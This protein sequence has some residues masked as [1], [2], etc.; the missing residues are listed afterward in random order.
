MKRKGQRLIMLWNV[1][2]SFI[3]IS[4]MVITPIPSVLAAVDDFQGRLAGGEHHT[5]VV[6]SNGTVMAWGDNAYGQLGDGSTQSR[7]TPVQVEDLTN[8]QSVATGRNHS[9]ALK[10]DGTVWAWGAND[11]G[12][13]GDYSITTRNT[14][15]K[16]SF[17]YNIIA[18]AAA[19]D[20]SFALRNDGILYAWGD[21]SYVQL[22]VE[23]AQDKQFYPKS[24]YKLTNVQAFATGEQFALA[25]TGDGTLWGWGENR[26]CE[27][28]QWALGRVVPLEIMTNVQAIAAGG[29]HAFAIDSDGNLWGWGSN[30][31]GQLGNGL[32][33]NRYCTPVQIT[34]NVKAVT[35][36][37]DHTLILKEDGT[38]WASGRKIYGQLGD[39]DSGPEFSRE[40]VQVQTDA[41]LKAIA[42]GYNHSLALTEDGA[43]LAWGNNGSGQLGDGYVGD[44]H[45]RNI[46]IPVYNLFS[47]DAYLQNVTLSEG[48][49]TPRFSKYNFNYQSIVPYESET[50]TVT[51][52]TGDAKSTVKVSIN[53]G[54][55]TVVQSNEASPILSLR[56][57]SNEI[58]VNVLAENKSVQYS[59][60]VNV[61][62]QSPNGS[63]ADL[64]DIRLGSGAVLNESFHASTTDYTV[65]VAHNLENL[66]VMPTAVDSTST[67]TVSLNGGVEMPVK[68]GEASIPLAL[69]VG[70]NTIVIDV[71]SRDG[72]KSKRYILAITRNGGLPNPTESSNIPVINVPVGTSFTATIY[73]PTKSFIGE[74][75]GLSSNGITG[76]LTGTLVNGSGVIDENGLF[77]KLQ[78]VLNGSGNGQLV[79]VKLSPAG[80]SLYV[81]LIAS[82][83]L[84]GQFDVN[85]ITP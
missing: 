50:I 1:M 61:T 54:T 72:L 73:D 46:P 26:N 47:T 79:E 29:K 15:V 68:S 82:P 59:Y 9:L 20:Q 71:E 6:H 36:G 19:H 21:N 62:R 65:N 39:G 13:L 52:T 18:I 85:K 40:F 10:K 16:T 55:E 2:L 48:T 63:T 69:N 14:P 23:W 37:Y 77:T 51:P 75:V 11:R 78:G 35:A 58:R 67:I 25:L 3:I 64:S 60:V 33:D 17:L 38:L 24:V 70:T 42:T 30:E 57:G 31:Y 74:F 81:R 84:D 66:T 56:L 80:P 76:N 22:N 83:T 44:I 27:L 12:Q 41:K 7:S 4:G 5:L 8:V 53:G 34:D 49:L 28:G 32:G 43:V 45:N